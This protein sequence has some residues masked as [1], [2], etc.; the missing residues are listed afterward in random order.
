MLRLIKDE[1]GS[2]ISFLNDYRKQHPLQN[3][4]EESK[5]GFSELEL[6]EIGKMV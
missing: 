6:E 5:G 4:S 1:L 3:L 2:I